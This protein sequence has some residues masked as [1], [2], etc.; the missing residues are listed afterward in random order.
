[1]ALDDGTW[2]S[3]PTDSMQSGELYN[4]KLSANSGRREIS[5]L[6]QVSQT[7]KDRSWMAGSGRGATECLNTKNLEYLVRTASLPG[8]GP[9]GR[10]SKGCETSVV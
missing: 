10:M 7:Q 3:P 1:M 9:R 5:V 2:T 4:S 8:H 6:K